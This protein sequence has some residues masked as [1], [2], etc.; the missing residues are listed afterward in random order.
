[1]LPA[2][3]EFV[4]QLPFCHRLVPDIWIISE[5]MFLILSIIAA[6]P[7][8]AIWLLNKLDYYRTKQFAAWPQPKPSRVWG[9]M[10]YLNDFIAR[11]EPNRHIGK[12]YL[13]Y[14]LIYRKL[15]HPGPRIR[16][17]Q[18]PPW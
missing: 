8:L 3:S 11:G 4:V 1:M 10:K 9:H 5:D 2:T 6:L 7:L 15:I 12:L 16:G 17:N 13:A 18:G 14:C